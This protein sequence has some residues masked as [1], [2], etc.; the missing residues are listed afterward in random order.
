MMQLP[1]DFQKYLLRQPKEPE[2]VKEMLAPLPSEPLSEA[3]RLSWRLQSWLT[4]TD[5]RLSE[6]SPARLALSARQNHM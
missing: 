1:M 2:I 6:G 5:D 4:P 3:A